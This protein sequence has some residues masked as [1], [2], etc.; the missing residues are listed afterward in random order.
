VR[1]LGTE[2]LTQ[3]QGP[4]SPPEFADAPIEVRQVA[5][6]V[7]DAADAVKAAMTAAFGSGWPLVE[8]RLRQEFG[9]DI[10]TD[11]GT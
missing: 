8:N 5:D 4:S 9:H 1:S 3:P 6:R 10:G 7:A 11:Q 2:G